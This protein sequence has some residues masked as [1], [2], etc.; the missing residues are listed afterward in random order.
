MSARRTVIALTAV[1]LLARVATL[2]VQSFWSDEAA[3]V[4]VLR[5]SFRGMLDAVWDGE[6]TPPLFYVLAWLW[7][8]LAGTGEVALRLPSALLGTATVPVVAALARRAAAGAVGGAGGG[9]VAAGGWGVPDRAAVAGAALAALSPLMVWYGQEARAYALLMLLTAAATLA[10]LRV[11]EEP[12]RARL[13]VWAALA[14]AAFWSHHFAIFVVVGQAGW[15]LWLLRG[16][17]VIAVAGVAAGAVA[18]A[19]LLLHQRAAGRASFIGDV[20]LHT[21]LAQ[22]PKQ[23]LVGYDGPAEALLVAVSVLAVLVALAGLALRPGR[24][25][26]AVGGAATALRDPS[27]GLIVLTVGAVGVLLP[28]LAALVGQDFLIT[29]N[30]LGVLPLTLAL[31]AVGAVRVPGGAARLGA[32]AIAALTAVGAVCAIAV[33]TTPAYQRDDFRAAIRAAVRGTHNPRLVI[34]EAGGRV[35]ALLYLGSGTEVITPRHPRAVSEIDV[36][37]VAGAEPGRKRTTPQL[38]ANPPLPG[39]F[40]AAGE[41][42]GETWAMRRFVAPAAVPIDSAQVAPLNPRGVPIVLYRPR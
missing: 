19:P 32:A 11:L 24:S 4:D 37:V 35:P 22:V 36:F 25:G 12:S 14:V 8:K 39:G 30:L 15:A 27:P 40:V 7:S 38:P 17:A 41:A 10:L 3:T 29:R 13:A 31:L 23:V 26:G 42:H 34:T 20:P 5:H 33:A 18:L 9:H 16:R 28:G 2:D 21:R 6:S 1:A